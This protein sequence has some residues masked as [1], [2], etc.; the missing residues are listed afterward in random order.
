MYHVT[1]LLF[2]FNNFEVFS[3]AHKELVL[4]TVDLSSPVDETTE[5]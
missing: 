4:F 1:V 5:A 2:W 3:I